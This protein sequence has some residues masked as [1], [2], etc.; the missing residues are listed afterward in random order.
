MLPDPPQHCPPHSAGKPNLPPSSLDLAPHWRTLKMNIV[1][2]ERKRLETLKEHQCDFR[3]AEKIFNGL[4]FTEEDFRFPYPER[5]YNTIGFIGER[6]V[7][8]TYCFEY[9]AIRVISLRKATKREA[10]QYVRLLQERDELGG[11]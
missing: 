11:I 7:K 2:D 4:E 3:D 8:L 6:I 5:R 1:W 10:L 9:E